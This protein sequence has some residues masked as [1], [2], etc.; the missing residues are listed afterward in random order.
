MWYLIA[1]KCFILLFLPPRLYLFVMKHL[2][3][4]F[5]VCIGLFSCKKEDKIKEDIA[6]IPTSFTIDRFDKAFY[7]TPVENFQQLKAK[8]PY[9][10]PQGVA[11]T[12]WTNKMQNPLYR[13]LYQEVQNKFSNI[14][15]LKDELT[16]LFQHV[17]YYFPNMKTPR[18]NTLISEMD[19][20]NKAI[21]TDSLV[22]ISLDMYLGKE[23]KFYEFPDYLK[24]TF[25]PSQITQDLVQDLYARKAKPTTD[26]AFIAQMVQQGKCQYLKELLI[27]ES[28]EAE[29][30]GYT[31][32]QVQWCKA[33]EEYMWRFFIENKMLYESDMTLS[34]RFIN[35]GP[36][37]KF[38]TEIDSQS[39]GKVGVWFG[40]KIVQSFMKNNDMPL[41]EM[42]DMDEKELFLRSKYK[43]SK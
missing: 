6:V 40:W 4:I 12:V 37:S 29:I 42:L 16:A 43:P 39:P 15:P 22:I 25:E 36:F 28:T 1:N 23:H 41:Q 21:Y 9:F 5:F 2:I 30:M 8:Y 24:Q 13:E 10:F 11:D 34:R 35:P 19:Y 31:P 14:N 3:W 32:E 26:R 7:E 17:K 18:V 38:Y 27:P 20:E 33:N